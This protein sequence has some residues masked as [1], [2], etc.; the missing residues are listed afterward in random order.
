[1]EHSIQHSMAEM[2]ATQHMLWA[3]QGL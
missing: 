1:M 2:F 3:L